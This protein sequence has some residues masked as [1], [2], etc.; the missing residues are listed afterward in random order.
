MAN[1]V[2]S[3]V[4]KTAVRELAAPIADVPRSPRSSMTC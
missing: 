1:F 4:V 3:G 2:Q